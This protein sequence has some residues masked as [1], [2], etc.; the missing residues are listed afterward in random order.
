[1]LYKVSEVSEIA[2]ISVRTLHHYHQIGLLVPGSVSPAGYRLYTEN[3]LQRLQE[4]L[5]F[6]E[7]DFGLEEIKNI[8]SSPD[9]DRKN[10]LKAHRKLLVEKKKRLDRII[11]SVEKTIESMEGGN[12]MNNKEMF[13]AFD[14]R[15]LEKHREKYAEETRKKY[16]SSDAYR[17]SQKR[18]AKYSKEEWAAIMNKGNEI[19]KQLVTLMDKDPSDSKV[20]ELVGQ[21]RQHITD[22]FY[23]CTPEI[24][25]GLGQLYV[26]D[27]R[28]TENI[29]KFGQGLAKF[30]SQAIE[31]YCKSL[32]R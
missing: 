1:M 18:T 25:R 30:M 28:F 27:S 15:E 8:L 24:F 22:S 10:A 19:Y 13:E 29:D 14:M 2:G 3:D 7:L 5:F 11:M 16:G 20:Q 9:Y 32:E 21:W 31:I 23:T 17:E 12:S 4:I 6:K 26:E